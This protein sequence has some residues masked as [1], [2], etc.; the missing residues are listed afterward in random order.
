LLQCFQRGSRNCSCP[1]W[2]SYS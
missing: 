2:A 1:T